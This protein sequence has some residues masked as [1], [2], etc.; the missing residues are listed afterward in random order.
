MFYK[1]RK[2]HWDGASVSVLT[3]DFGIE[4]NFFWPGVSK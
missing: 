4:D 1:V 3:F 2:Q